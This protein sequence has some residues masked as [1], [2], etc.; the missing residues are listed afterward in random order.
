MGFGESGRE[1]GNWAYN[2]FV[3]SAIVQRLPFSPDEIQPE[4]QTLLNAE[5]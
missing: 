5:C 4:D 3:W 1:R 2:A